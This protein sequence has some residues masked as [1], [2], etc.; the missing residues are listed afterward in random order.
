MPASRKAAWVDG[1][2]ADGAV[3]L[4]H[5]TD[6]LG[7]LDGWVQGLTEQE[8]V[9]VLPLVRRTFGSFSVAERRAV[10]GRLTSQGRRPAAVPDDDLDDERADAALATVA[11]VLGVPR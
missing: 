5:D 1:F 2:F 10:A 8:F 4:I 11:L 7:L 6:L 3:L 9:D